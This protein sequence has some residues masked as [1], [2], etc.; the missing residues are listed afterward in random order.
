MQN[1]AARGSRRGRADIKIG[2]Q[3]RVQPRAGQKLTQLLLGQ[4]GAHLQQHMQSR[5]GVEHREILAARRLREHLQQ[6][7]ADSAVI[8]FCAAEVLFKIA[9]CDKAR[10]RHLLKAW[11]GAGIKAH[12]ACPARQKRRGQNHIADAQRGRKRFGKRVEVN[13]APGAIHALHRRDGQTG[14][15]EL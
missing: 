1:D 13:D 6:T 8:F 3:R 11:Y 4:R 10:Q 9:L 14:K 12:H 5:T 15:A 2:E 7:R